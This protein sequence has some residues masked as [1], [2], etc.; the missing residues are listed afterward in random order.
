M[1]FDC[2]YSSKVVCVRRLNAPLGHLQSTTL[3]DLSSNRPGPHGLKIFQDKYAGLEPVGPLI[4]FHSPYCGS[5]Q[6]QY[7]N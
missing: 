6:D 4:W 1:I 7:A 5:P 2:N 3:P